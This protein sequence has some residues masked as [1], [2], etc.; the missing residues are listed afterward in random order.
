MKTVSEFVAEITSKVRSAG[1]TCEPVVSLGSPVT[2]TT[3][4]VV[5]P[6]AVRHGERCRLLIRLQRVAA[7]GEN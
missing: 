3:G 5:A 6:I 7:A 4:S 2:T 1:C